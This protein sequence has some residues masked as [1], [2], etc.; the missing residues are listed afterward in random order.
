MLSSTLWFRAYCSVPC[1][2]RSSFSTSFLE[3]LYESWKINYRQKQSWHVVPVMLCDIDYNTQRKKRCINSNL[4]RA[5]ARCVGVSV[6]QSTLR[7]LDLVA[8][9]HAKTPTCDNN[10]DATMR[11]QPNDERNLNEVR[12]FMRVTGNRY[13]ESSRKTGAMIKLPDAVHNTNSNKNDDDDDDDHIRDK[14]RA[15]NAAKN[16]AIRCIVSYG[17]VSLRF[18]LCTEIKAQLCCVCVSNSFSHCRCSSNEYMIVY[19][20]MHAVQ[21]ITFTDSSHR[22]TLKIP[23]QNQT[24]WHRTHGNAF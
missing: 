6:V 16:S 7:D 1:F 12:Y 2:F 17:I 11:W 14:W 13:N 3:K 18:T 10:D 22:R 20:W 4:A 15:K 8:N 23:W 21:R 9:A 24:F 5:H 19:R